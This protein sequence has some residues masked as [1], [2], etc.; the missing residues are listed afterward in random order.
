MS[1]SICNDNWFTFSLTKKIASFMLLI[2]R[3]N[4]TLILLG[5]RVTG[6]RD[7]FC[8]DLKR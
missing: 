4:N 5:L 7:V 3:P 1:S 2:T 8:F 6:F